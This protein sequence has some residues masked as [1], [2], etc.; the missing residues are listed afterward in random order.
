MPISVQRDRIIRW[1]IAHQFS[2]RLHRKAKHR[3][4]S[5]DRTQALCSVCATRVQRR[6]FL[7]IPSLSKEICGGLK[8]PYKYCVLGILSKE[9][10]G[11]ENPDFWCGRWDLNPYGLPYA[12]QT[13]A[14]AYSATTAKFDCERYYIA[15]RGNCQPRFFKIA[16]ENP[17]YFRGR[18]WARTE[19]GR[20]AVRKSGVARAFAN[21]VRPKR[22]AEKRRSPSLRERNTAATQCGKAEEP[23][24]SR[25]ELG[26]NAVRK[27][28]GARACAN[29]VRPQRSA[30]KRGSPS[31][32]E[33]S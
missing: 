27:S 30:E 26:R 23:E 15:P 3:V 6:R 13:Y 16:G 29:G 24:L 21:G 22:S 28:G 17:V 14:S 31:L 12:P 4:L 8:N 33:R 32:R 10:T 19:L 7:T 18:G 11:L 5:E 20:N 9:K 25:T 1:I 2:T